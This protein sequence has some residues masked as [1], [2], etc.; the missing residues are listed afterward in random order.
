MIRS[1]G[2]DAQVRAGVNRSGEVPLCGSPVIRWPTRSNRA[3]CYSCGEAF[4][5]MSTWIM[6]PGFSHWYRCTGGWDRGCAAGS[7]PGAASPRPWW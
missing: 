5:S 4:G 3:S 6:S 1:D 7:A 2:I